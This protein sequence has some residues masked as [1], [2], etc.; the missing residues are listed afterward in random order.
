MWASFLVGNVIV[1][2]VWV[3]PAHMSESGE[4]WFSL[5]LESWFWIGLPT[6]VSAALGATGWTMARQLGGQRR[7]PA[8]TG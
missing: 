2:V 3:D 7:P 4:T 8:P 5:L 1:A 6:L